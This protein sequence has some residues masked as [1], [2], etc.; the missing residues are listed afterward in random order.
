MN[1][2]K[3]LLTLTILSLFCISSIAQADEN[4]L[5]GRNDTTVTV[6]IKNDANVKIIKEEHPIII[7]KGENLT[8]NIDNPLKA[9]LQVRIH[10]SLGRLVKQYLD[11]EDQIVM[12]TNN[13]L[14]GVYLVIIKKDD[15][16]E[17]RKVLITD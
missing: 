12:N 4:R 16:R 7:R 9:T 14:S 1:K 11:V 2:I 6:S 13:L 17:I 8:I 3:F 5:I 10:S 15:I